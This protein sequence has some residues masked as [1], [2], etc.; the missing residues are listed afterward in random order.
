MKGLATNAG[1]EANQMEIYSRDGAAIADIQMTPLQ[2][3]KEEINQMQHDVAS[4][5]AERG[6]LALWEVQAVDRI[7]PLLNQAA[8]NTESALKYY[9]EYR[10]DLWTPEYRNLATS[11]RRDTDQVARTLKDYLKSEKI[12]VEEERLENRL[13]QKGD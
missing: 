1:Y 9:N 7:S 3:L 4:L 12:R 13:N 5:E 6:S 10:H 2:L 11:I 8:A